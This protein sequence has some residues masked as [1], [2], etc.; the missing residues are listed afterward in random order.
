ME[1]QCCNQFDDIP[2]FNDSEQKNDGRAGIIYPPRLDL[3]A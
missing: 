3:D 1:K 2:I